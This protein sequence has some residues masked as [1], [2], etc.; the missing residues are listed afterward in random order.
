MLTDVLRPVVPR[1]AR[2]WLRQWDRERRFTRGVRRLRQHDTFIPLS[3]ETLDDLLYGWNNPWSLREELICQL[4]DDAWHTTGPILECGSGLSTILLAAVAEKRNQLVVTLEHDLQ[5]HQ[6]MSRVLGVF[7]FTSVRLVHAPLVESATY[8]W[9]DVPSDLPLG[10]T[11][12]I[13]DGPPGDTR[14]GRYGLLPRMGRHLGADCV[15]LVDDAARPGEQAVLE[16]WAEEYA[17]RRREAGARKPYAVVEG[18]GRSM[19]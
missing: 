16:R 2:S 13:C 1:G 17:V 11:L 10:I 9:Y 4:W 19:A 15:I 12:V 18:P 8:A 7:G 6:R 14:G 5:W 3:V